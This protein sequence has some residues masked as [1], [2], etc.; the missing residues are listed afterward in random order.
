LFEFKPAFCLGYLNWYPEHLDNCL[1]SIRAQGNWPVT[2]ADLGSTSRGVLRAICEEHNTLL[3]DVDRSKVSQDLRWSR[4][5]ALNACSRYPHY[6]TTH[7]VFTDADMI[8]PKEWMFR[9]SS[10]VRTNPNRL[11]LTPSRDLDP[12]FSVRGS[13]VITS[14]SLEAATIPHPSCGQGAAMVV[15]KDWFRKVRGFDETF[16][17]WGCEDNDLALRAEADGLDPAWLLGIFVAHQ[18]HSRSWPNEAQLLQV[19]RNRAY[20]SQAENYPIVRNSENWAGN[21]IGFREGEQVWQVS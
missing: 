4:S 2:V 14:K 11:W 20:F 6:D 17:V 16:L 12:W 5:I 15:P 10:Q 18:Y 9:V 13:D 1:S 7:Y 8:F 3:V 19:A 21:L